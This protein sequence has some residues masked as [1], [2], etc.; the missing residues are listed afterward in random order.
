LRSKPKTSDRS[1][2][3][4]GKL[5]IQ[6]SGESGLPRFDPEWPEL[7]VDPYPTFERYRDADPVHWGIATNPV[8][9]GSWYTFTYADCMAV[10][11]DP[12]FKSN[13]ESVGMNDAVLD[14]FGPVASVFTKFIGAL[15]PPDHGRIRSIMAKAFTPRRVAEM[16]SRIEAIASDL[17]TDCLADGKPFDLVARFAFPLPMTIIGE[18]L[19]VPVEDREQ[20][21]ELST[22]FARAVDHPGNKELSLAG[23]KAAVEMLEYFGREFTRRGTT[24]GDDLLQAMVNATNDEGQRMDKLEMQAIAIE[25]IIAGHE[26]TVNATSKAV[27]RM[28][29]DGIYSKMALDPSNVDDNAVE[30]I[31][32]WTSPAQRQRNRWVTEPMEFGG[33]NFEVGDSVVIMLAAANHDA[34]KFE[35]P[36][37]L[38]FTREPTRHMA[39]GHGPHFC[40]GAALARLEIGSAFRA[41]FTL[42][43]DLELTSDE[44]EWRDNAIIPGPSSL[45]VQRSR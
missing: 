18:M 30:E 7:R 41:L 2:V 19:G 35:N 43:P 29:K 1:Q 9:P 10:M 31:L 5:D 44:V 15:D 42:A 3:I 17:M 27:W 6:K 39:F 4:G 23:G 24:G 34:V 38:D 20:F 40:M 21:R 33:R 36:D 11:A 13:P 14:D 37:V 26:T 22:D 25:M 8:L 28:L 32:R 16:R 45:M 12:R